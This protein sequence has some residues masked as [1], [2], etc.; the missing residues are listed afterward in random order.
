MEFTY[1]N[2]L[3]ELDKLAGDINHFGLE[4]NLDKE[5]L[6]HLNLCLDEL[7][8]N[9]ILY[10]FE[11]KSSHTIHIS[12]IKKNNQLIIDIIDS[13]KAFDPL[14]QVP[15]P[16][17]NSPV[18]ERGIGGLGIFFLKKYSEVITYSRQELNN[19]LHFVFPSKELS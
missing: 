8:T 10:A 5:T 3:T 6:Y 2:Q 18:E 11:D 16:D 15:E 1:L 12:L 4:E 13:G 14:T 7:L 9:I 19:H 17:L